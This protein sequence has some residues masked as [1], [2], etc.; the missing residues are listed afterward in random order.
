MKLLSSVL[1]I[2]LTLQSH[3]MAKQSKKKKR[4][5][6]KAKVEVEVPVNVGLGPQVFLLPGPFQGQYSGVQIDIYAAIS[7]EIVRANQHKI[8]K[9]FRKMAKGIKDEVHLR[10]W[11]L[12]LIPQALV[13]SPLNTLSEDEGAAYGAIWQPFF[14][15]GLFGLGESKDVLSFDLGVGLPSLMYLNLHHQDL[16][17]QEQHIVGIGADANAKVSLRFSPQW[18]LQFTGISQAFFTNEMVYFEDGEEQATSFFPLH[19]VSMTLNYRFGY[20][21]KI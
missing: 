10:P 12:P 20:K 15:L 16:E 8:P 2:F 13:I 5:K 21:T 17:G 11:P 7:P 1:I 4:H 6:Q 19:R 18:A 3:V 14:G 9:K